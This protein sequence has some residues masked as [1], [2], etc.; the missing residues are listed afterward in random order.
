MVSVGIIG[1][2]GISRAHAPGWVAHARRIALFS[3]EGAERLRT[4]IDE[5]AGRRRA[6]GLEAPSVHVC[7]SLDELLGSVDVAD[8]CTPTD[9]HA[10]IATRAL[11]ADLDVLC[12]KPLARTLDQA[13]ALA[14]LA[15]ERGRLLY[16]AHVVRFFPAYRR[17]REAV[18]RGDIGE[19]AVCRFRR[20]GSYPSWSSWFADEA[21]SG[22]LVMDLQIHDL[23]QA[24]W[25]AG[26]VRSVYA[27][28][29]R[30]QG[31]GDLPIEMVDCTLTHTGGAISQVQAVWGPP[32]MEFCTELHLSGSLGLLSY[33][34]LDDRPIA[35]NGGVRGQTTVPVTGGPSPYT[36]QI[37]DFLAVRAD[38]ARSAQVSAA[39]GVAA[40]RLARAVRQSLERGC[41]ITLTESEVAS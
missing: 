8:V 26:P 41:S 19:L 1:T 21:R 2:G 37:E 40:I 24:V 38:R 10:Q 20:A 11:Q 32:G 12:E 4:E 13:Q 22:G 31:E 30:A 23:D 25:I 18:A 28:L 27:T 5:M 15:R 16:P 9:T 34:S 39:D 36:A 35:T 6:Q 14:D 7:G 29:S 3:L 17:A 33:S